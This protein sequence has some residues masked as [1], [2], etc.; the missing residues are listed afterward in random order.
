MY[1]TN[2]YTVNCLVCIVHR[3]HCNIIFFYPFMMP[4]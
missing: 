1:L 4:V 2:R 3:K